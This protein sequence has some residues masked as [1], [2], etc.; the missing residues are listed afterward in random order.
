[1][2]V[3]ISKQSLEDHWTVMTA[4]WL[5]VLLRQ[6]VRYVV[7]GAECPLVLLQ[8]FSAVLVEDGSSISLPASLCCFWKGCGGN[9]AKKKESKG[10]SSIKLTVRLDLLKGSLQ[11]PYLHDGK[12][13]ELN[14]ELR[15]QEMPKGSLWIADLGYFPLHWLKTLSKRGVY[16][17]M[18]YKDAVIIWVNDKRIDL[19]DLLPKEPGV[20]VDQVVCLGAEKLIQVRLIAVA[21]PDFVAKQ[22]QERI[23]EYARTHQKPVSER[24][25]ELAK[26]TILV[27]NVPA[28]MLTPLEAQGLLRARWQIEL[29]FK[30]W[31]QF[32][33]IDE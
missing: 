14:S 8:R 5:L 13:H 26:W 1:M 22:R 11:G 15:E 16:F 7:C 23:R 20:W 3:K 25:L 31:K 19:L 28:S 21:V 30:L 24:A 18:R 32:G 10:Q 33:L 2:G 9:D 17:L 4:Q 12:T 6:A 27:T 29:L